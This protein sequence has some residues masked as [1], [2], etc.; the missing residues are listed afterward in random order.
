LSYAQNFE[1]LHFF[2]QLLEN[3]M[4]Y[5]YGILFLSSR[6]HFS[7]QCQAVEIQADE[8]WAVNPQSHKAASRISNKVLMAI[9]AIDPHWFNFLADVKGHF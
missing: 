4:C 1:Q 2:D 9:G 8:F 6:W 3:E 7:K 5:R